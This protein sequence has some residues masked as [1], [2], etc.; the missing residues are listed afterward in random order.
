MHE[1]HQGE[2]RHEASNTGNEWVRDKAEDDA[3]GGILGAHGQTGAVAEFCAVIEPHYP[4]AGS[5]RR[6]IGL[7]HMLRMYFIASWFTQ[8]ER[9]HQQALIPEQAVERCG[10]G[11]QPHLVS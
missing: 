9:L 11:N 7:E 10:Q 1:R 2:E 8:G 3:Q 4:K 5:G 6:P